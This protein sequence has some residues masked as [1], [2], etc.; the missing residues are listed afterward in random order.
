MLEI[1]NRIGYPVMV[2][3][4]YVLGGRGMEIVHDDEMV[5]NLLEIIETASNSLVAVAV[6]S[7]EIDRSS[8]VNTGIHFG[9]LKDRLTVCIHDARDVYKRQD[10]S[11]S[12]TK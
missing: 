3:P 1:A 2:R 5:S 10:C 4:S 7:V 8:A 12:Y 9:S 11:R 6:E